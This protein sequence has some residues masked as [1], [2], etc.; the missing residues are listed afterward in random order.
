[1]GIKR[2]A[3]RWPLTRPDGST[4]EL[5]PPSGGRTFSLQIATEDGKR[6][7]VA[8]LC[9][10]DVG[11]E[12]RAA[13]AAAGW[14][15][16]PR[17]LVQVVTA[18]SRCRVVRADIET[19]QLVLLLDVEQITPAELARAELVSTTTY[20]A[21]GRGRAGRCGSL[22]SRRSLACSAWP[23]LPVLPL[24]SGS[25]ALRVPAGSRTLPLVGRRRTAPGLPTE[26]VT[27]DHRV[28]VTRATGSTQLQVRLAAPSANSSGVR[29]ASVDS[30]HD[31]GRRRSIR[32]TRCSSSATAA[33]SPPTA[34]WRSTR[35][36]IGA[37]TPLE[38]VWG[39]ADRSVVATGGRS[40]RL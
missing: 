35:S 26:R 13:G 3:S 10:A 22:D 1:M 33:S 34:S 36:F 16:T 11:P 17:G 30:P 21:S 15:R 19:E 4:F 14:S 29:S 37:A 38:L 8:W 24:M 39:V 5:Q 20:G 6:H 9:E 31:I 12:I 25:Y 18:K 27:D 7:R 40:R 23:G 2:S 32:P 28:V